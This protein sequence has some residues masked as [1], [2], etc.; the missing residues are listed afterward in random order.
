MATA[1]SMTSTLS[2]HHHSCQPAT[3][4]SRLLLVQMLRPISSPMPSHTPAEPSSC[5]YPIYSDEVNV[6]TSRQVSRTLGRTLY[7][8]GSVHTNTSK[9]TTSR[10]LNVPI[11]GRSIRTRRRYHSAQRLT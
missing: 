5:R 8:N 4:P 11:G 2:S 3:Q 6:T 10:P 9:T 7:R 1:P